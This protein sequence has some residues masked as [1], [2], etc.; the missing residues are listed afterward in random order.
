MNQPLLKGILLGFGWKETEREFGAQ[1]LSKI[2][3][4]V[5]F[6]IRAGNMF[7]LRYISPLWPFN[8]VMAFLNFKNILLIIF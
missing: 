3:T 8:L 1:I 2:K 6:K 7:V 5:L 4:G